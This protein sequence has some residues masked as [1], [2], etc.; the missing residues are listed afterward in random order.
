MG[1]QVR[2][3]A[4][5]LAVATRGKTTASDVLTLAAAYES[6]LENGIVFKHSPV[7]DAPVDSKPPTQP[8]RRKGR[9]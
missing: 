2:L 8:T 6:F 3:E 1:A 4:L 9:S 7:Q 5:R